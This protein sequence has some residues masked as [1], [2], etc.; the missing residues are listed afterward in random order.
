MGVEGIRLAGLGSDGCDRF[1]LLGG[2][3][4]WRDFITENARAVG[5]RRFGLCFGGCASKCKV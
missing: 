5:F 4:R 3:S 1:W 2:T